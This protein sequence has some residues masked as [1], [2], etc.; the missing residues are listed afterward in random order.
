MAEKDEAGAKL[1][2]PDSIPYAISAAHALHEAHRNPE[3]ELYFRRAANLDPKV[4]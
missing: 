2:R 4:K 3:A 1:S